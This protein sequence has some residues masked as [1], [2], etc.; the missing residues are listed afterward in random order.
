MVVTQEL[1]GAPGSPYTRKMLALMRY[2]HIP[3]RVEWQ[4]RIFKKDGASRRPQPKV[5]LLPTFYIKNADGEDSA[6]TDSTPILRQF[7]QDYNGRHVIPSDPALA[8]L[9]ALVEDYADEWLTKSMFHYRWSYAADIGQAGKILPL[10]G[11]ITMPDA[12]M[13]KLADFVRDRQIGRLS[14]VG[15]NVQTAPL[16]E[17][18]FKR[19]LACAEAHIASGFPFMFGQRP[20]SADFAIYGQ[21]TCLAHFDPTPQKIILDIAP[22]LYAWTGIME[23]LSGHVVDEAAGWEDI[24]SIPPSLTAVLQEIG[25]T[26]VPYLLANAAAVMKGETQMNFTLDG[27][28]WRQNPFPY[29]VKCLQ[30]LREDYA[31]LSAADKARFDAAIVHTDCAALFNDM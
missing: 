29:Q 5:S 16:I 25:H 10:W 21:L 23:D 27:T 4:S 12:E 18:S 3:Y 8:L 1:M 7:E 9:N 26:Y 24:T 20:A 17:A 22:R 14:Y 6:I 13:D 2:R 31:A 11:N 28:Q 15:S 30:W 19:F